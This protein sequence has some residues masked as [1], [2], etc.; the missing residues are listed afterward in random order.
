MKEKKSIESKKLVRPLK[1]RM[2]AG[3]AS[4][5]A[6]YFEI[7]PIIIRLLFVLVTFSVGSGVLIYIIL[8][9]VIPEEGDEG[10]S[11]KD[12]VKKNSKDL[13]N[14]VEKIVENKNNRKSMQLF[15]GLGLA[16]FGLYLLM[17]NL[18][19][20]RFLNLGWLFSN[21]W[22]IVLIVL[23]VYILIGRKDK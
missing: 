14:T 7:D 2:L 10:M 9:I 8:W 19:I 1:D 5:L 3:V 23:G 22:P 16:I 21:F 20:L 18:G 6:N 15:F 13:E 11:G 17:G 4:G 12:V